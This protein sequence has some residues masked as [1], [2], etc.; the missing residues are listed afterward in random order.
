MPRGTPRWRRQPGRPELCC[1]AASFGVACP[2][3]CACLAWPPAGPAGPASRSGWLAYDGRPSLTWCGPV[4]LQTRVPCSVGLCVR[5]QSSRPAVRS[6]CPAAA[7][8]AS[9]P[10]RVSPSASSHPASLAPTWWRIAGTFGALHGQADLTSISA[11]SALDAWATGF[12]VPAGRARRRRHDQALDREDLARRFAAGRAG[13]H[14]G[15]LGADP[16]PDRCL[17]GGQRMGVQRHHE[18][19]G[20]VLAAERHALDRRHTARRRRRRRASG[21]DHGGQGLQPQ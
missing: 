2:A 5:L 19:P 15:Q 17:L 18:R 3:V 11:P 4:H 16:G 6:P 21:A 1:A 12:T 14:L 10:H 7:F 9:P 13:P 20:A 8:Q